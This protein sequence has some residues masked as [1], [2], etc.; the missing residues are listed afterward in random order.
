M[1]VKAHSFGLSWAQ[2]FLEL[3]LFPVEILKAM[4]VQEMPTGAMVSK[5]QQLPHLST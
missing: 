4:P 1:M 2:Y 5:P 3:D